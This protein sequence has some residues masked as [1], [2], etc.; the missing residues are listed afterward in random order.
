[1]FENKT[2]CTKI[3]LKL[4]KGQNF[5]TEFEYVDRS[6]II[7]RAFFNPNAG[8]F[9]ER[10]TFFISQPIWPSHG[11][12]DRSNVNNF[13]FFINHFHFFISFLVQGKVLELKQWWAAW[14]K[15]AYDG[16]PRAEFAPSDSPGER[17]CFRSGTL[18]C[19]VLFSAISHSSFFY[20]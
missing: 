2:F 12:I 10:I 6:Q 11:S 16:K 9:S 8:R 3:I 5:V 15:R 1:M 18:P 20:V 19:I 4:K 13:D 17:P 7:D 14:A